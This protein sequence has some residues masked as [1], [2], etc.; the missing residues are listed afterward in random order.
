MA[1]IDMD[2]DVVFRIPGGLFGNDST[3]ERREGNVV[4]DVGQIHQALTWLT[5]RKATITATA[6]HCDDGI[7][8]HYIWPV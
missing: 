5:A 7:R 2:R 3:S 1:K 6:R 4:V 8:I